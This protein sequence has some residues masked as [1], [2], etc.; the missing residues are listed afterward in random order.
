MAHSLGGLVVRHLFAA[1]SAQPQ[2]RI[3]TLG[4][5]HAGSSAAQWIQHHGLAAILGRSVESGLGGALPQWTGE[6]EL[7]VVAGTLRRGLGCLIP[8]L[9]RPNDGMVTV[10][11]TRIVGMTDHIV[12]PVSHFGMLLSQR[13]AFQVQRFLHEGRFLHQ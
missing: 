13:V 2:G 5:P 7:G 1:H 4:T 11:E 8:G 10:P 6:R 12:L 3:V 9:E